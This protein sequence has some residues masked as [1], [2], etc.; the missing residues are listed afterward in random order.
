MAAP[1]LPASV[2]VATRTP[3]RQQTILWNYSGF[4][5]EGNNYPPHLEVK[6]PDWQNT[7]SADEKNALLNFL[8]APDGQRLFA[9]ELLWMSRSGCGILMVLKRN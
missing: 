2:V 5:D 7:L 9:V 6:I 3:S 4:F 8:A 1:C